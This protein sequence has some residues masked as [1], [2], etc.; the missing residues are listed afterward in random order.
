MVSLHPVSPRHARQAKGADRGALEPASDLLAT[1][2][3]LRER[4]CVRVRI[5]ETLEC[6]SV[7]M[8]P[9]A[10]VRHTLSISTRTSSVASTATRSTPFLERTR[11]SCTR[12]SAQSTGPHGTRTM[13]CSDRT[14]A[15]SAA[16]AR[17]PAAAGARVTRMCLHNSLC[18]IRRLHQAHDELVEVARIVKIKMV[19]RVADN[20]HARVPVA[21]LA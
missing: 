19:A 4:E 6:L 8:H 7:S 10:F 15:G 9:V 14:S 17:P 20:V 12:V 3:L 5:R 13:S 16:L 21:R 18:I 11:T 2:R 1:A